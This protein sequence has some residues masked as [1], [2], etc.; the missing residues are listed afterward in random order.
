MTNAAVYSEEIVRIP[1]S[2]EAE[3]AELDLETLDEID[4]GVTLA[5]V[6]SVVTIVAGGVKI[7]D[8][9]GKRAGWWN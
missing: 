2:A 5:T 8:F 1:E 3:T 4:G 7:V 9:V 6:A